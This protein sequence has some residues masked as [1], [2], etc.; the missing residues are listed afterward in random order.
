MNNAITIKNV[1]YTLDGQAVGRAARAVLNLGGGD[2]IT[3]EVKV[4]DGMTQ[5]DI[6]AALLKECAE[7]WGDLFDF[8]ARL[9]A[10]LAG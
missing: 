2:C 6:N 10:R 5:T 3:A 8:T 7:K 1:N 4:T 9:T